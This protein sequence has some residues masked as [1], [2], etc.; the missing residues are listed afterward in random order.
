M[1]FIT[2][3]HTMLAPIHES[4]D[5]VSAISVC[6]FILTTYVSIPHCNHLGKTVL[7]RGHNIYY[8]E[9]LAKIKSELIC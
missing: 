9:E 4:H 5:R 6:N 3:F 2:I 1:R 7:M 8:Y